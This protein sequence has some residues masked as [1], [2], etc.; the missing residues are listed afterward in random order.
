MTYLSCFVSGQGGSR[1]ILIDDNFAS[2]V[3]A[4]SE[5]RAA[6]VYEDIRVNAMP[7]AFHPVCR[8]GARDA[9]CLERVRS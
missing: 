8:E 9:P 5:G 4:S 1:L 3:A 6:A 7:V 2:I